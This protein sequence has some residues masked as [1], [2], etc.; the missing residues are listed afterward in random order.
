MQVHIA[1]ARMGKRRRMRWSPKGAY[2]IAVTKTR[3]NRRPAIIRAF[4][5][6]MLPM[7]VERLVP[8][9][10]RTNVSRCD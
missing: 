8:P 1:N 9:V 7:A 10:C 6:P 2:R 3:S 5:A 4:V